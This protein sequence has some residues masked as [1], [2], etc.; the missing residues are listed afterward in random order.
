VR[1]AVSLGSPFLPASGPKPSLDWA[2]P[3]HGAR[4]TLAVP[5]VPPTCNGTLGE[6]SGRSSGR[7]SRADGDGSARAVQYQ[8]ER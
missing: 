5:L 7:S 2:M 8:T 6:C 1:A 3:Q 4:P